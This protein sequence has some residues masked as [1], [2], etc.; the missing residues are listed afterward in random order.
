MKKILIA[1]M[2]TIAFSISTGYA[3]PD[4]LD[5]NIKI[6]ERI[7]ERFKKEFPNAEYV[8]W[9]KNGDYK[10]NVYHIIE[11]DASGNLKQVRKQKV[12]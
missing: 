11:S 9:Y 2:V 12:G 5:S 10:D 8:R 6:N 1:L 4:P 7:Q 3:K